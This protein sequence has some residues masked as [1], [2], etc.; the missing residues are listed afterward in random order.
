MEIRSKISW[1]EGS[2]TSLYMQ[3]NYA[4]F[5]SNLKQLS[6]QNIVIKSEF[7]AVI[8]ALSSNLIS[9]K[10]VL[11][12]TRKTKRTKQVAEGN[13]IV[14]KLAEKWQKGVS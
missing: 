13:K 4:S 14:V 12:V 6:R 1:T 8:K 7:Q 11:G 3:W 10:M 9:T 2:K 5:G